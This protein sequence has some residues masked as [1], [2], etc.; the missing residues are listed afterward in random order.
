MFDIFFYIYWFSL[1]IYSLCLFLFVF[2]QA[3][4]SS[5]TKK[6]DLFL[7]DVTTQLKKNNVTTDIKVD[8]NSNVSYKFDSVEAINIYS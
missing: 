7:A 3:I 1:I 2:P 8:T 4:T 6:G 5:G